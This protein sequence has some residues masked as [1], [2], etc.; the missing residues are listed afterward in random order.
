MTT[1]ITI[2]ISPQTGGTA[3]QTA[4]SLAALTST[5]LS[6]LAVALIQAMATQDP[7][8]LGP[9]VQALLSAMPQQA[10]VGV[11]AVG[12]YYSSTSGFVEKSV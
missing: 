3:A 9:F 7:T 5:Q 2:M 11:P 6:S 10:A 12:K 1:P 8:V 4:T